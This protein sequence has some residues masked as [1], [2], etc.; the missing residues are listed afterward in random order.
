[1]QLT[2]KVALPGMPTVVQHALSC[3]IALF[4]VTRRIVL[5]LFPSASWRQPLVLHNSF[6]YYYKSK[7]I[8]G[9]S[10]RSKLYLFATTLITWRPQT[11]IV[12]RTHDNPWHLFDSLFHSYSQKTGSHAAIDLNALP[13][14]R[15]GVWL[16]LMSSPQ[17]C[18]PPPTALTEDQPLSGGDAGPPPILLFFFFCWL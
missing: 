5:F 18:P 12:S 16:G 15:P 10:F 17:G 8:S 14:L 11:R 6:F 9:C 1:M 3:V 7:N 4:Y 13:F 2:L